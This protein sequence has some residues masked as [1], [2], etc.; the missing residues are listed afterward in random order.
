MSP[1]THAVLVAIVEESRRT[2]DPVPAGRV[3]ETLGVSEAALAGALDSLRECELVEATGDGYRPTVTA[4]ELLELDV[5]FDDV[6]VLDFV[7]E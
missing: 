5:A 4:R 2:G 3:A 1:S 6:L 7:E